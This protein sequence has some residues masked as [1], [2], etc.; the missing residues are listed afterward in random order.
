MMF[1]RSAVS[2]R[3]ASKVQRSRVAA[4]VPSRPANLNGQRP[5][6]PCIMLLAGQPGDRQGHGFPA[7][8]VRPRFCLHQ[9][10]DARA[11]TSG[12]MHAGLYVCFEQLFRACIGVALPVGTPQ[13]LALRRCAPLLIASN[14]SVW[15][16]AE[17]FYAAHYAYTRYGHASCSSIVAIC[18]PWRV[19]GMPPGNR[20]ASATDPRPFCACR[21][22]GA[23]APSHLDGKLGAWRC[24]FCSGPCLARLL[25]HSTVA[26]AACAVL[27]VAFSC[28]A[29]RTL[30]I[31]TRCIVFN[32][33]AHR[34]PAAAL[35][36]ATD[37]P[38]CTF[39]LAPCP[40]LSHP[41]CAL[42]VPARS[43]RLR[44]RPAAPGHQP[45]PAQ[46]VP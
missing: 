11:V 23:T 18:Q 15:H 7:H 37:A 24:Q 44:L 35:A 9:I 19:K 4:V 5:D 3:T 39:R 43:R 41:P 8:V 33:R 16:N 32:P 22:P 13:Q 21:Y 46:V 31:P 34:G 10:P 25:A 36:T 27:F 38:P 45:R 14:R 28:H 26:L 40:P 20:C 30:C 6:D 2:S 42:S 12:L 29:S 1:K 17:R